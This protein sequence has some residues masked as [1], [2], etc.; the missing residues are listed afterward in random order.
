MG[1]CRHNREDGSRSAPRRKKKERSDMKPRSIPLEI[2]AAVICTFSTHIQYANRCINRKYIIILREEPCQLEWCINFSTVIG[3]SL[4]KVA[5]YARRH[6][7]ARYAFAKRKDEDSHGGSF[8]ALHLDAVRL[9]AL[10]CSHLGYPLFRL[11]PPNLV[12]FLLRSTSSTSSPAPSPRQAERTDR[13]EHHDR[14]IIGSHLALY[15]PVH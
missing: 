2:V 7:A 13:N 9:F 12:I 15:Y 6:V 1:C 3:Q 11:L 5:T 8:L 10:L 14:E 4:R